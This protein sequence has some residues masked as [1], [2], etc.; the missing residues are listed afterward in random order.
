MRLN[1]CVFGIHD[2]KIDRN[3]LIA[4]CPKCWGKWHCS[5]DMTCGGTIIGKR[6]DCKNECHYQEPYGFVSEEGC[7]IHDI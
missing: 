1:L 5:Y 2:Y 3:K 4:F 6:W 7:E